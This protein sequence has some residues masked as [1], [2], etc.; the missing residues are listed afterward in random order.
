MVERNFLESS[1]SVVSE[2]TEII[3]Q[4]GTD[5]PKPIINKLMTAKLLKN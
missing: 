3:Y 2:T 1:G 4:Y 5:K